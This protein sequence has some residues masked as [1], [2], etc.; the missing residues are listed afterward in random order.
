M[1]I[2]LDTL[3]FDLL[4]LGYH[5]GLA[6]IVGGG[7][8][9]GAL[10][11]PAVFRAAGSRSQAGTIFGA[12]LERSDPAMVLAVVLAIATSVLRAG[13]VDE[14]PR[15][16]RIAAR[17]VLLGLM[18]LATL[19]S[20]GWAGPIARGIRSQ[21]PGFDD[22]PATD[23]RRREFGLLHA[24]SRRAMSVAVLCGAGA[25]FLS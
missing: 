24:R 1:L 3:Y 10:V 14:D 17:W 21:T 25:L 18:S 22:L 9:L 20:A 4:K 2:A 11:A 16:A 23:V 13:A 19:F 7:V 12:V 8:A 5:L 15:D 6:V